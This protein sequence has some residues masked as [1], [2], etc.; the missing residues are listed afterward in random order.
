[1]K[2]LEGKN[3]L[4]TGASRGIGK[5]IALKFA[6]HGANVGFTFL[7]SVEKAKALEEELAQKGI[8]A[9]GFQ[10]DASDFDAAE[11]LV[12]DFV[13]EFGSLDV[14]INNAGITK[15]GLLMR[16]SETQFDEVISTNLKSIFNLT[17]SACKT[18]MKQRAGSII[19]MSSVVGVR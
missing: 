16:M 17:K 11:K 15:D 14:L 2:L 13:E 3:A 4:I 7:S 9:K 8:K 12:N 1:M 6:E 18:L 10:S 19:N 5:A